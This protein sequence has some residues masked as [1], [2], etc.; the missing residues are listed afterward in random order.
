MIKELLAAFNLSLLSVKLRDCFGKLFFFVVKY[1]RKLLRTSLGT[2]IS[3]IA[4]ISS[5]RLSIAS[6]A[7][8]FSRASPNTFSIRIYSFSTQHL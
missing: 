5:L 2:K 7:A 8:P 6:S 4:D 1:C 3:C